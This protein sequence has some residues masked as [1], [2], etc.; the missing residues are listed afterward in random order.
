[1][2]KKEIRQ[3]LLNTKVYVN[4]K[5]E[6]IQ[7]KLFY[8]DF[9]WADTGK[10]ISNLE[11]PFIIIEP[12]GILTYSHDMEWFT[13]YSHKEITA[14][15]I[16]NIQCGTNCPFKPFDKVL[17]RDADEEDYKPAFFVQYMPN[18]LYPYKLIGNDG[19]AIQCIPYEG[20]EHLLTK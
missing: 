15:Y 17:V 10:E 9:E 18:E 2:T 8:L 19:S 4:G 12:D 1:M 6:E 14:D 16:L 13:E 20:N 3:S 5:S 11:A 7:R